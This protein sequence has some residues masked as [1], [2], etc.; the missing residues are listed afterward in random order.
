MAV[1]VRE[2]DSK[3]AMKLS[4]V[5]A[6][7]ALPILAIA[8]GPP[9]SRRFACWAGPG[10]ANPLAGAAPVTPRKGPPHDRHY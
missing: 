1:E 8:H 2:D 3:V 10:A 6:E 7:V 4:N 5:P 9:K